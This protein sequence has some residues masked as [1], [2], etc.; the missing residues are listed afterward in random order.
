MAAGERKREGEPEAG[1]LGALVALPL[2][3]A[4]AWLEGRGLRVA[5]C[6]ELV[7]PRGRGEPGAAGAMPGAPPPEARVVRAR[8]AGAGAVEILYARGGAMTT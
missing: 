4:L 3:Q 2:R 6:E 5:R 7:P 8:A 1:E